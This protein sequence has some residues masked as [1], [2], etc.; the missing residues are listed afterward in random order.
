MHVDKKALLNPSEWGKSHVFLPAPL[1]R[2]AQMKSSGFDVLSSLI[3]REL[4]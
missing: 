2:S 4:F 3:E 1:Q